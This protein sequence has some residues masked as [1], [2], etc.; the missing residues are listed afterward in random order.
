MATLDLVNINKIYPNGVQAVF[1]FNL[2]IDEQEFIIFVGPSGCGKSTTL[3]MIAGLEDISSGDLFIDG[4]K[5]NNVSPK[6]RGIAFGF[7]Q[8]S[9][10]LVAFACQLVLTDSL[11]GFEEGTK[12]ALLRT[13]GTDDISTDTVDAAVEEVET[14]VYTVQ[15]TGTYNLGEEFLSGVVHD[16]D[17]VGIPTDGTADMQHELGNEIEECTDLVGR[18]LCGMIMTCIDGLNDVM[19]RTVGSIEIM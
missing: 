3:R 7:L 8:K 1:D 19:L 15:R 4:V 12:H 16:G 13:A 10:H 18:T 14:I 5:M 17:M 2:H 11:G 6:D 9:Q